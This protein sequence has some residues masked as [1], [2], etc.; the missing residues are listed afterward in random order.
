MLDIFNSR[1]KLGKAVKISQ[2]ETTVYAKIV[3]V[4]NCTK[5]CACK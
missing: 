2:K 5:S 1:N 4:G 3:H